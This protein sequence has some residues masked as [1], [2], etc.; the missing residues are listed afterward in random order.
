MIRFAIIPALFAVAAC[1]VPASTSY[2]SV[3]QPKYAEQY[4]GAIAAIV[5]SGLEAQ[6][7]GVSA[8]TFGQ[9][10]GTAMIAG[11][12][13]ISAV[14]AAIAIKLGYKAGRETHWTS[15]E[16]LNATVEVCLQE[17]WAYTT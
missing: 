14:D 13:P 8:E 1:D 10:V 6:R 16:M 9:N 4:C 11:D 7:S 17:Q 12:W 2:A 5:A 3:S 15:D